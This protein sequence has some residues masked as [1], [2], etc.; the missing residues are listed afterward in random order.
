[1]T[2]RVNKK[3]VKR[4]ILIVDAILATVL[5]V[6]TVMLISYG[7]NY[8]KNRALYSEAAELAVT[9]ATPSP[10]PETVETAGITEAAQV[11]ELAEAAAPQTTDAW[12]PPK[13]KPPITVDFAA[14]REK[15]THVQAWLYSPDTVINYPVVYYSNNDYY[16]THAYDGSRSDG[17]ALF[18][19][20]RCGKD[21]SGQNLIIYGHHMKDKS[22]FGSLLNYQKK[23]YYNA[24]PVLYL[25]TPEQNY[26]VE[27]FAA[28]HC[29]SSSEHFPIW[30]SN[31]ATRKQFIE[32][33]ENATGYDMDVSFRNQATVLSLV[34]C[35]YSQY[36]DDAKFMV[37]GYLV[38]IG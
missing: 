36:L 18:F 26:R 28:W 9:E 34:T 16:L 6:A 35:S 4:T 25:L 3:K 29:D 15:G 10:T 20:T 13:E 12:E 7:V 33:A 32:N 31:E 24:H 8:G 38:P 19:D 14:I 37:N 1:M 22:M 11:A 21:L 23:E 17:G 30:F 5:V 2:L 27:V